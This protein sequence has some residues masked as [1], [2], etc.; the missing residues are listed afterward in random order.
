MHAGR[1]AAWHIANSATEWF[2]MV[3]ALW[4]SLPKEVRKM[5]CEM[6]MTTYTTK[7]GV[8]KSKMMNRCQKPT[9]YGMAEQVYNNLDKLDLNQ[10]IAEYVN[11]QIGDA[12]SSIGVDK[13]AN[14]M[15]N[16]PFGG[17]YAESHTREYASG[18]FNG[19]KSDDTRI[20]VPELN[21]DAAT[22]SYSWSWAGLD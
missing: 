10:F 8:T 21:Y 1:H 15:L 6:K 11:M 17:G 3:E 18:G 22:N 2:D 9:P 5:D 20:P 4:K 19:D 13:T 12:V 16:K 14:Q 7:K